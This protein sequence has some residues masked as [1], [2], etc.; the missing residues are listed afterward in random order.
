M[1]LEAALLEALALSDRVGDKIFQCRI[2]NT[3]GWAHEE[4]YN[5]QTAIWYNQEGAEAAYKV[6]DPEIIR[7][8]EINLGDDYLLLGEVA[9]ARSALSLL[10]IRPNARDISDIRESEICSRTIAKPSSV[11]L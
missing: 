1:Q 5:L 10:Y 8:A 4:L 11:L 6:G 7:K 9:Q 2:L 3:L